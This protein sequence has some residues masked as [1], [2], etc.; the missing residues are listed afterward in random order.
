MLANDSDSNGHSLAITGN[1]NPSKGSV[2]CSAATCN[3][4]A[5]DGIT[6]N[7]S[8]SFTY[9]I[10]DGYGGSATG[11]VSISIRNLSEGTVAK[12]VISPSG[13]T[14]TGSLPISIST[15]TS[16]ATIYYTTNGSTPSTSSTRY[17]GAFNITGSN[18]VK[19]RAYKSDYNASAIDAQSFVR[20][21]APVANGDSASVDE[22]KSV[23]INV[24][25]NDSDSNG[26]SLA[27]TGNSNPS[28]G[29]VNCSAATCNYTANDGITANTSDSFTYTITDGYG[30][31]ATGSVS[32]SIRNLSE[33]TVAK[34]VISPSGKTFTGSLPISISTSTSG[35]TIYYTTN[36][37]NP[38]TSS[39]RYTGTF[40]I[41]SDK[42]I[43][44]FAV[45]PDF[46][47]SAVDT[48]VFD[49]NYAPSFNAG[50]NPP[51]TAD[52]GKQYSFQFVAT[53]PENDSLTFGSN[54]KPS[55]LSLNTSTG[56]LSGT[57]T[58]QQAGSYT[59][60]RISVSDGYSTT[61]FPGFNIT[62]QQTINSAK[63]EYRYDAL[64]RLVK[65]I[66]PVNGNRS[67]VL[68]AAGNRTDVEHQE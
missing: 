3:Y 68:D 10:T 22:G 50:L 65:V 41:S 66:D 42:T 17:T 12:P 53:D 14:F 8:D 45:K 26:H 31:S 19:A 27:I 5:N 28:K 62:V 24:L 48:D 29:S 16:G 21:S 11:S 56:V 33:G 54:N 35:A 2:N 52:S 47:N 60:I 30:G 37:S 36:G 38:S 23:A 18:T 15:S 63:I 46:N 13:K 39:T 7:T 55:W 9:T 67:Y 34:P 57:P 44:A 59:N 58:A 64:G 40:N 4:T 43:K 32:I 6:A 25:A 51:T 20:N 1:S 61:W 49:R